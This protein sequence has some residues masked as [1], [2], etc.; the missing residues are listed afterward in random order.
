MIFFVTAS[1]HRYAPIE[2]E[3]ISGAPAFDV[4]SYNRLFR[5]KSLPIATY[6]FTDFDRLTFWHVEQAAHIFRHLKAAGA[7]VYNDPA[8][9]LQ[10]LPLLKQ[11]YR[12][13][14]NKFCV[15]DAAADGLPDQFPVFLRTRHAHRGTITD[16]LDSREAAEQ[17][18]ETALSDGYGVQDLM[19]TE[20]CAAPAQHGIF[21]KL[22]AFRVGDTFQM[23]TAVHE[24]HW[25]AKYGEDGAGT[26]A[27]YIEDLDRI[28]NNPFTDALKT[29][30]DIAQIDYGRADFAIVDGVPQ[31][32]EIN[33][34]PH[35]AL[36]ETH[37]FPA[38]MEAQ[39]LFCE[40]L[41]AALT[42]IDRPLDRST[43]V[44]LDHPDLI[45][46]RQTDRRVLWQ[47]SVV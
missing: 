47:R 25:Q 23:T 9:V 10:R 22:A 6:V 42:A 40:R 19:F 20:Y 29:A 16:L 4:I 32:Y 18:L 34:N 3:D 11:L 14:V 41:A 26:E 30:F 28:Q 37:P 13:G 31:I 38:R 45:E 39:A 43:R 33:T 44:S 36:T 2:I 17:A 46:M 12:R 27:H 8:R 15:W 24:R 5:R 1:G 35:I 21:C 7:S